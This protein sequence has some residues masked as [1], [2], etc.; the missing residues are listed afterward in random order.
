MWTLF[1]IAGLHSNYFMTWTPLAQLVLIVV[2]PTVVLLL[3]TKFRVARLAR[4]QIAPR[5]LWTAFYFTAPFLALDIIYLGMH[6]GF[7]ASF[8]LSHW[9]LTAFY[10]TPWLTLPPLLLVQRTL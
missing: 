3:V 4:E 9:Y 10:I 8:L 5:V 6:Q 1:F 2:L 7:G